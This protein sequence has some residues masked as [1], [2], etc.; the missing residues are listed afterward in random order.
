MSNR[1]QIIANAESGDLSRQEAVI[2]SE[3]ARLSLKH[4]VG[5]GIPPIPSFFSPWFYAYL[6][7]ILEGNN[8]PTP[9][10]ARKRYEEMVREEIGEALSQE[11]MNNI[12]S[13]QE[14]TKKM[15]SEA[16]ESIVQAIDRIEEHSLALEKHEE[17]LSASKTISS[18]MKLI[19]VL[20]REIRQL[21]ESNRVTQEKLEQSAE[22]I[23]KIEEKLKKKETEAQYDPLTVVANR[24]L[25][26]K[27]LKELMI[28]RDS[29]GIPCSLI[30]I[31]VDDFKRVNDLYG[32]RA[33]DEVLRSIALSLEKELRT[34]DLVARY[35]GEEFVVLLPENNLKDAS[36]VAERL[37]ERIERLSVAVGQ[38]LYVSV[39]ISLGVAEVHDGDSP[40]EVVGRADK[41]LYLAKGAGKNCVRS[42]R[43]L[44]KQKKEG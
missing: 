13:I 6:N 16:G 22:T 9:E 17:E 4:L 31:D 18:L 39:T 7:L 24:R 41:A 32:H 44:A 8:N 23:K 10:E 40:E 43:D 3:A 37:R 42:E 28:K 5:E 29:E 25:F 36:S 15:M 12:V 2:I 27:R 20:L 34:E 19:D 35:G 14:D 38:N 1:R 30:M 26:E 11:E 21:R 33:G